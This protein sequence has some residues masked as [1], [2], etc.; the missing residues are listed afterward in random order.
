ARGAASG[1]GGIA[2]TPA[3]GRFPCAASSGRRWRVGALSFLSDPV[4]VDPRRR[5]P[6]HRAAPGGRDLHPDGPGDRRA[7]RS[8]LALVP[9][10]LVRH[11]GT[12]LFLLPVGHPSPGVLLP[13]VLSVPALLSF[14]SPL[15]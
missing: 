4:P 5:G 12:R 3:L 8:F 10:S 7:H 1:P 2:G 14:R 6:D 9:L 11:R 13:R 15:G